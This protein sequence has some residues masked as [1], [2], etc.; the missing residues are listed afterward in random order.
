MKNI[1]TL[2]GIAVVAAALI[3]TGLPAQAADYGIVVSQTTQVARDA[4]SLTVNVAGVP[5]KTGLY[6]MYCAR[7]TDAQ[8]RPT[9]CFGRGVWI[10]TDPTALGQGAVDANAPVTL[11]IALAFTS[12]GAT[13]DC[14]KVS[15]GVYAVSYTHL[16][17]PTNRE[18]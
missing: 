10:S 8:A 1:L 3:A 16:T 4:S 11:P 5:A 7:G 17:L 14:E 18:V 15:C 9:Q 13:V 6:V 2:A 12:G